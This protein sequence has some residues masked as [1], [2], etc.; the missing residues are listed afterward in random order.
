MTR[1]QALIIAARL[2]GAGNAQGARLLIRQ[3]VLPGRLVPAI[4]SVRSSKGADPRTR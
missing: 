3:Y 4:E 1:A 2:A